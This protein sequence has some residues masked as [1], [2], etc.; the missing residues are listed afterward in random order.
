MN[1]MPPDRSPLGI[2]TVDLRVDFGSF[3]AVD[4]L[5]LQVPKGEIYG[6]IGP[7]GAGKTTTF[8]VLARKLGR[9]TVPW[10]AD[11]ASSLPTTLACG[12]I[13]AVAWLIFLTKL[14]DSHWY[15]EWSL[16]RDAWIQISLAVLLAWA[17]KKRRNLRAATLGEGT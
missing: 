1:A 17:F 8:R 10:Y 2:E 3:T 6:L 15:P 11:A 16:G 12:V 9:R 13:G 14:L 4:D 5:S 7:N